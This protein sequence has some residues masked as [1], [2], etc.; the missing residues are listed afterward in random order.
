MS[1]YGWLRCE[2][3]E[4]G[5]FSDELTVVVVRSNGMTESY[6]VPAVEVE[7]ERCRVRVVLRDAGSL[8]W[9]TLPTSAPVTIHVK[10]SHVVMI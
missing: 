9:A 6:F 5:M 3:V 10:K 2:S 1:G 8:L 7:R 4:C